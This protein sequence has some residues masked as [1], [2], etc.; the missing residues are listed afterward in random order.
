[1]INGFF[2]SWMVSVG[3][4]LCLPFWLVGVLLVKLYVL[5]KSRNIHIDDK[6]IMELREGDI[7]PALNGEL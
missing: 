1:M 6:I 2:E 4:P 3:S 5:E 7:T